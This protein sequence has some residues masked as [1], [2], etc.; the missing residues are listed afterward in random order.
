MALK[1]KLYKSN[2]K[3]ETQG[4]WYARAMHDETVD[5]DALAEI[6]QA[7]CTV[8]ASDIV[9]VLRE[10]VETMTRELQSSKRVK[11]NGFGT[12]KVGISS[13]GADSADEYK[14]ST[15][16]RGAH[17]LFQPEASIGA[18]HKRTYKLLGGLRVQEAALYSLD[19][20]AKETG[21]D[22]APDQTQQVDA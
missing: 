21:Q 17:V 10:L 4:K 5:I 3:G 16:I 1:F 2:R 15:H 20:T 18:D 13:K 7:N 11:I 22:A 8:K 6:M 9:A 12:F 19:D 14:A